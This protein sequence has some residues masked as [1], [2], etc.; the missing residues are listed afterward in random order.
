MREGG[1]EELKHLEGGIAKE[2][3]KRTPDKN[4]MIWVGKGERGGVR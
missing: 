2:I 3:G 1:G 4:K